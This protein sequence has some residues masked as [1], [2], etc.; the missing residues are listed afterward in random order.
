[1]RLE[2]LEKCLGG[3]YTEIS[4]CKDK[5]GIMLVFVQASKPS[6]LKL[7]APVQCLD[8]P[9]PVSGFRILQASTLP[10]CLHLWQ[11]EPRTPALRQSQA[12]ILVPVMP[13]KT[14]HNAGLRV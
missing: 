6:P 9:Q 11:S 5:T 13:R 3:T 7:Y 10:P 1:M 4:A 2:E 8:T 14:V 12:E